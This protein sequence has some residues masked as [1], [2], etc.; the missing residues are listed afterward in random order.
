MGKHNISDLSIITKN[1]KQQLYFQTY[2]NYFYNIYIT[3]F[4]WKNL[5]DEIL[6]SAIEELLFW[7]GRAIFLREGGPYGFY[8][9]MKYAGYGQ[10][11][12]Y[13]FSNER[14][15]M[16]KQYFEFRGKSDSVLLR[17][18]YTDYPAARTIRMFAASL[19]EMRVTRDLNLRAQRTPFVTYGTT[20]KTKSF[21]NIF[22]MIDDGIPY[23]QLD[24]EQFTPED[25]QVLDVNAPVVFPAIENEMRVEIVNCL[26]MLGIFAVYDAKKERLTANESAGNIGE[27]EMNRNG[28]S[29]LRKRSCEQINRVFGLNVD[30]EFNSEIEL[31]LIPGSSGTSSLNYNNLDKKCFT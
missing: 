4:K 14:I 23:I 20:N 15:G 29:E 3:R 6:P 2:F 28:S 22:R 25:L 18:N 17:D 13:G 26:A 16:A 10:Q 31:P 1:T 27:I 9:V 21:N 30:V 11:D 12:I 19:A 8:A 7:N 5:P 24:R